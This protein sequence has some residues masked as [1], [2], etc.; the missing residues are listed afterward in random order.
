MTAPRLKL[1]VWTVGLLWCAAVWAAL[2]W[3]AL[4]LARW[5]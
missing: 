5:V 1:L 4:K 3:L 2:G